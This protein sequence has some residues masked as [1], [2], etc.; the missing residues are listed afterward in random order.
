M[1]SWQRI[2][3]PS[4]IRSYHLQHLGRAKPLSSLKKFRT[5]EV[6]TRLSTKSPPCARSNVFLNQRLAKMTGLYRWIRPTCPG[7]TLSPT[8]S[9][10]FPCVQYRIYTCG[11][12]NV[13]RERVLNQFDVIP[14]CVKIWCRSSSDCDY[15]LVS[16]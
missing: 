8:L 10:N 14:S 3:L 5:S 7:W 16:Y 4:P 15:S 12:L 6:R 2:H 11:E 9:S 13:A 1:F